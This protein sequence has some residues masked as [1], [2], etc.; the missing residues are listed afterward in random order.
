MTKGRARGPKRRAPTKAETSKSP[1][2]VKSSGT[3]APFNRGLSPKPGASNTNTLSEPLSRKVSRQSLKEESPNVTPQKPKPAAP[4][5]SPLL[6]GSSGSSLKE[7]EKLQFP[8][9]AEARA[10]SPPPVSTPSWK[11]ASRQPLSEGS[12][13][14]TLSAENKQPTIEEELET[15][16]VP[17]KTAVVGLGLG[18]PTPIRLPKRDA[19]KGVASSTVAVAEPLRKTEHSHIE[20][21]NAQLLT[22][23]FKGPPGFRASTIDFDLMSFFATS[24]AIPPEKV[25]TIRLEVSE[26]TGHGKLKPVAREEQHVFFDEN[27]YLCIHRFEGGTRKAQSEVYFWS[28]SKVSE[29]AV[30][31]AQLFARKTARESEGKLVI[32]CC[33]GV[34][35]S[36]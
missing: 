17:V 33:P 28:G 4:A 13:I 3:K 9:A 31:D 11:V 14:G 34:P 15:P 22:E 7:N 20:K 27:M 5:K 2:P 8:T 1:D 24:P 36:C 6:R 21:E 25:K 26:I 23:F 18:P 10:K 29:S 32:H 30:E 12:P 16:R 19:G 35:M